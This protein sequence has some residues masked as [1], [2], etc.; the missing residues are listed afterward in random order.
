MGS[1]RSRKLKA[2]E[3]YQFG[4]HLDEIFE[5]IAAEREGR[6]TREQLRQH[7]Q[8]KHENPQPKDKDERE[9]PNHP[10]YKCIGCIAWTRCVGYSQLMDCIEKRKQAY[11]KHHPRNE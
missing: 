6:P 8:G 1:R 5:R 3:E 7:K 11:E 9:N 10:C 4:N 2:R